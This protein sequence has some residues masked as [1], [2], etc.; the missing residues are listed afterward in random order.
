M[1]IQL[2]WRN[3]TLDI[4]LPDTWVLVWPGPVSEINHPDPGIDQ[5]LVSNPLKELPGKTT[6]PLM[7]RQNPGVASA[8]CR[9][10]IH[11]SHRWPESVKKGK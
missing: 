8:N 6:M 3:D 2:P 7:K 5:R 9:G 4:K 10:W 11:F 1:N